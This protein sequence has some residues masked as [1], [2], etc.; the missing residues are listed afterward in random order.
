MQS[1]GFVNFTWNLSAPGSAEYDEASLEGYQ[2]IWDP[3]GKDMSK[4]KELQALVK[5]ACD[6]LFGKKLSKYFYNK[7]LLFADTYFID[8]YREVCYQLKNGTLYTVAFM[9]DLDDKKGIEYI[10]RVYHNLTMI[11]NDLETVKKETDDPQIIGAANKSLQYYYVARGTSHAYMQALQAEYESKNGKHEEAEKLIKKALITY[12]EE[13][14]KLKTDWLNIQGQMGE[15]L[16]IESLESAESSLQKIKNILDSINV[17]IQ[18]RK[19]MTERKE[20]NKEK[21]KPKVNQPISAAIFIPDTKG[22]QTYG[23]KS[24]INLLKGF[25]D[26]SIQEI[27]DLSLNTLKK[28]DCIIF[29]DCKSFG[30]VNVNL[31]DIRNYVM[32]NG[33]GIYFEHDSCGF[34][35]F[36]LRGSTFPEIADVG[37]RIGDV[38]SSTQYKKNDR[39]LKIVEDHPITRGNLKGSSFEQIYM[40]HLQLINGNGT[41][42]IEDNYGKPVL[43]AGKIGNGKVV[44]YGGITYGL[45]GDAFGGELEKS[46]ETTEGNIIRNSIYW[47]AKKNKGTE[48]I[49]SW[50]EKNDRTLTNMDASVI[51]FKPQII[52]C[53]TLHNVVLT[54][55]CFDAKGLR[56]ISLKREI[57]K[58]NEI[59]DKWEAEENIIIN[60]ESYPQIKVVM[61]LSSKEGKNF[62]SEIIGNEK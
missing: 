38:P 26:I 8:H 23:G 25:N 58:I 10:S 34:R 18:S 57:A 29:P 6:D 17:K 36:P 5:R 12:N 32:E 51:S 9:P 11:I 62:V 49:M 33:G 59:N 3:F 35:R 55:Q 61:E 54:V 46:L 41:V 48:L 52:P 50:L 4:N 39:I 19:F 14:K 45:E 56:P 13:L 20:K 21:E 44:F 30:K 53:K 42:L 1:L 16:P 28:Y 37:E 47:L 2:E 22:G 31:A 15:F 7:Y 24:L 40:D 60:A 43:I 27:S